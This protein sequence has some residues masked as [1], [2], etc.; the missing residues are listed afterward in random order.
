MQT[1]RFKSH[2]HNCILN[3][4]NHTTTITSHEP[5]NTKNGSKST[6]HQSQ[7]M[8]FWTRWSKLV[9][10]QSSDKMIDG[11]EK[12]RQ[13]AFKLQNSRLF[14]KV[15]WVVVF[16]LQ[17]CELKK[18]WVNKNSR[19]WSTQFLLTLFSL[20]PLDDLILSFSWKSVLLCFCFFH[21]SSLF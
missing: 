15:Q 17:G 21:H 7:T 16:T 1:L 18:S 20:K 3:A 2:L 5:W 11:K 14:W 13:L 19:L 12:C 6:N 8:T 10:P 4:I 9:S